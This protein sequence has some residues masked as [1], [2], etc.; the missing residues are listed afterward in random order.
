MA[1]TKMIAA[2]VKECQGN[3]YAHDSKL[4]PSIGII[5]SDSTGDLRF[6][7]ASANPGAGANTERSVHG[8]TKVPGD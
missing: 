2:S 6:L 3:H 7:A 1:E 8:I 5:A 4:F